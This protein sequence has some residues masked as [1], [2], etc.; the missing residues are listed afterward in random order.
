MTSLKINSDRFGLSEKAW[1]K[2]GSIFLNFPEL[3]RVFL[4]GSRAKGTHKPGSDIDLAIEGAS[5]DTSAVLRL[6]NALEASDLPYFFDVIQLSTVDSPELLAH[7]QK[8][9]VVIYEPKTVQTL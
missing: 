9:G 3:E 8:L 2:L 7:I 6:Q 4:F 1:Q 5:L